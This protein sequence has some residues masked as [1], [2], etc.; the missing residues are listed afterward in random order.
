MKKLFAIMLAM[1]MVFSLCACGAEEE[2]NADLVITRAP[3]EE[4]EAPAA[5]DEATE[6]PTEAEGEA[7]PAVI[8]VEFYAFEAEGVQLVPGAAFDADEMPSKAS[9]VYTVPSC[10]LEGTDNVYNYDDAFE[11]TAF[12]EGDGEFIYSVYILD[13]NLTTPEGLALGDSK[14]KVVQLYG[15]GYQDNGNEYVYQAGDTILDIIFQGDSVASIEYRM[16][17]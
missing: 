10:A 13:P 14:D 16:V 2:T 6:A 1:M 3:V 17:T 4:T 8:D 11:V 12:D 5:Q 9:S 7:A 15:A